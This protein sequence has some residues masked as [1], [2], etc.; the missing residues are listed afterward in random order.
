MEWLIR[1]NLRARTGSQDFSSTSGGERYANPGILQIPGAPRSLL[2]CDPT[3]FAVPIGAPVGLVAHNGVEPFPAPFRA[4]G[5]EGRAFPLQP[6]DD[7][8]S[9]HSLV[10]VLAKNVADELGLRLVYGGVSVLVDA[11]TVGRRPGG[12]TALLGL[13]APVHPSPF[14][15]VVQLDLADGRHESKGIHVD[16]RS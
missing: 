16:G 2:G 12:Q 4:L 13:A 8:R 9:G 11:V 5:L 7:G 6:Q 10:S 14:P 3:G 1:L 15:K